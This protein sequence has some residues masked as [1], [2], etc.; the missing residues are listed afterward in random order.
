MNRAIARLVNFIPGRWNAVRLYWR[1]KGRLSLRRFKNREELFT[2]Y[3]LTNHWGN[4]ES[5]S[6]DGFDGKLRGKCRQPAPAFDRSFSYPFAVGRTL[7]RLQL[8]SLR[9]QEPGRSVSRRGRC[10]P[11][12]ARNQ[13]AFGNAST[14]FL[15]LD[16]L[17][18]DLPDADLWI[19]RDCLFHFSN[20]DIAATM[21]NFARSKI[22]Y[23]LTSTHADCRRNVDVPTGGFRLLN[24]QRPP[25]NFCTPIEFIDDWVD[26]FPVKKLGLWERTSLA[27]AAM[28]GNA[29][30]AR[31]AA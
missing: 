19:C 8:V 25:F 10:K 9:R 7:W 31:R 30:P 27:G 2:H 3:Y 28:G 6:G 17:R 15:H 26:G 14:R 4:P 12:I 1:L 21:E 18:D 11:L 20:A 29:S 23:L 24:L 13:Q 5:V 16:I 22:R